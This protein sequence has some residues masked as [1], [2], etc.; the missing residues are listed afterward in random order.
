MKIYGLIGNPLG[1]SFSQKYFTE[2]FIEENLNNCIYVNFETSELEGEIRNL[3][4]NFDLCGLNITIPYKSEIIAFLDEVSPECEEIGACNCIKIR[5]RKWLGFNTDII[6]FEKTFKPHL[7]P[8]HQKALILGTGGSSKAI[9]YVLKKLGMEYLFVSRKNS[10]E[11]RMIDYSE[12]T[13]S[14]DE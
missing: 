2:K 7:R 6:G 8:N 13:F 3:K 1:H 5:D 9:A 11:N 12:I 10:S 14:T 4:N